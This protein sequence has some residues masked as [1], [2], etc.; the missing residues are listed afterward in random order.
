MTRQDQKVSEINF[1]KKA[2][3]LL[4]ELWEIEASIDEI[5]WPDLIVT[6]KSGKFGLEVREIFLDELKKGS[7]KKAKEK[8]NFKIID[9]LAGIYYSDNYP[10]IKVNF[11]GNITH[12]D[13]LLNTIKENALQLS[14]SEQKRIEP[15]NG[16]VIYVSRLPDR[17]GKYKKWGYLSDKVGWVRDIDKK[18]I[19]KFIIEKAMS[20]PKYKRKISD[21]RLLLV[22]NRIYNSSRACLTDKIT[23]DTHGFN[24]IYYLSYP[25][26]IYR[27]NS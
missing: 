18:V 19:D 6:T 12:K 7:M 4:D 16:C 21:V 11:L 9:N 5:N 26:T 13:E 15:Y 8:N 22:S 27:L 2:G 23:C 10:S 1:A 20:L 24:D 25:E 17:L 14:E 3:E